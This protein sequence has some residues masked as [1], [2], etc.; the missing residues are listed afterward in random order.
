MY[1]KVAPVVGNIIIPMNQTIL[2]HLTNYSLY[3]YNGLTNQYTKTT[4]F[5]HDDFTFPIVSFH[6][7]SSNVIL[8]LVFSTRIFSELSCCHKIIFPFIN[9]RQDIYRTRLYEK[10]RGCL[11]S[12]RNCLPFASTCVHH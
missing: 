5:K 9:H 3:S 7:I 2:L 8:G 6:F 12:N 11:I 1:R 4:I 10:H